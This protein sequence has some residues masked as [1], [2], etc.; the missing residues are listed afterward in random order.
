[1]GTVSAFEFAS[2]TPENGTGLST[3]VTINVTGTGVTQ[4]EMSAVWGPKGDF[5][6]GGGTSNIQVRGGSA[7]FQWNASRNNNNRWVVRVSNGTHSIQNV[8]KLDNKAPKIKGLDLPDRLNSDFGPVKFNVEEQYGSIDFVEVRVKDSDGEVVDSKEFCSDSED[9]DSCSV[10]YELPTGGMS[11]GNEYELEVERNDSFGEKGRRP[12]SEEFTYDNKYKGDENPSVKP[13]PQVFRVD[14]GSEEIRIGVTLNGKSEGS[15]ISVVCKYQGG[16]IGTSSSK[17]LSSDEEETFDCTMVPEDYGNIGMDFKAVLKDEAGN[18]EPVE[19]GTYY[20]D[21]YPPKLE[22]LSA[23]VGIFNS[24]FQLS[25]DGY[26][27]GETEIGKIHYQLND[28]TLDLDNGYNSTDADGDFKV[29]TE[30]LPK[31]AHTVYAWAVD[32]AGRVSSRKKFTFDF[33]PSATP[34]AAISTGNKLSTVAGED[35]I[36]KSSVKNT[37]RLYISSMDLSLVSSISNQSRSLKGL[38]PG[39]NVSEYFSIDTEEKDLGVHKLALKTQSPDASE[40]VKLVVKAN[41]DQKSSIKDKY[42]RFSERYRDLKENVTRLNQSG[43]SQ[44][45]RER[46]GSNTSEF[47]QRMEAAVKAFEKGRFYRVDSILEN[48]QPLYEKASESYRQVKKEHEAAE[49]NRLIGLFLL[50][51]I[52]LTGSGVAYVAWFSEEYYIDIEALKE[53]DRLE[54]GIEF[55]EEKVGQYELSLEPLEGLLDGLGEAVEEEEEEL[56]QGFQGFS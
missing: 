55:V 5:S 29:N 12:Y 36:V 16:K 37:G 33:R 24:D 25:Y 34:K 21:F 46:L 17:Y 2:S 35:V 54:K 9:K 10:S 43:L 27:P 48:I 38:K 8:Y 15:E 44:E 18:T 1:M 32:K 31:G 28:K 3:P 22:N 39:E 23:V 49:F 13:G 7:W 47:F 52:G 41:K 26:D 45:R 53:I 42:E 19:V 30:G 4:G 11:S 20:F 40:T 14:D 6:S 56:E 50:V 51:G